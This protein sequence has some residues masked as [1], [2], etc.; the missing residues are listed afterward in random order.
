MNSDTSRSVPPPG[1]SWLRLVPGTRVVVRRRLTA[2]EA[3]AARSD[4]RGAVWTDVI[5]FVLTVSDDGVGVRTDPR[6]GYGAPEEL[7]VAADL[8]A[9]AKPIPPRRIRNP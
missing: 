4:R 7:W 8:I 3:V 1:P 5:G 2:A 9:S 6:P